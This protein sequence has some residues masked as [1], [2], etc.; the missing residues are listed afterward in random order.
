[1]ENE[2]SQ[3][4]SIPKGKRKTLASVKMPKVEALI[5]GGYRYKTKDEAVAKIT[6]IKNTFVKSRLKLDME[7][8][9]KVIIWIKGYEITPEEQENG[10]IGNFALVFCELNAGDGKYYIKTRKI[11]ADPRY[12]PSRIRKKRSTPDWGHFV[13]RKIKKGHTYSSAEEANEDLLKIAEDL[14]AV[15]IPCTNKLYTMIYRK[16]ENAEEKVF[17]KKYVF[18]VGTAPE[19][20][21]VIEYKENTYKGKIGSR[22]QND[23]KEAIGQFTSALELKR[24]RKRRQ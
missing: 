7:N 19:V 5:S 9:T 15:S 18:E 23:K 22:V 16:P 3:S 20:G 24:S 6:S 8:D 14:P 2:I 17:V 11:N 4:I 1:M 10:Y 12:H 13:L 21:F